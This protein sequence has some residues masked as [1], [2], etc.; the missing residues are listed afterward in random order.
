MVTAAGLL[1]AGL[2]G[3]A[4][5]TAATTI[6]FEESI[7]S[8]GNVTTQYCNDPATNRGVQFFEQ[9]RLIEPASGTS[10]PTHA[11][12]NR[13]SGDEFTESRVM[14]IGF[15]A[16]Q[17]YVSLRVGLDKAYVFPVTAQLRVFTTA[18]PSPSSEIVGQ[19]D[20]LLLGTA[21]TPI[22]RELS[23]TSPGTATP[24]R[25]LEVE[26]TGSAPGNAAVE[27]VDDLTFPTVG[28]PC[29]SDTTPPFVEILEPGPGTAYYGD[30]DGGDVPATLHLRA[31][32]SGTGVATVRVDFV[33]TR[34][35]VVPGFAV[36][37]DVQ[38]EPCPLQTTF[39]DRRFSTYLPDDTVA[40]RV[41]AVDFAGRTGV[42]QRDLTI[43]PSTANVW[44]RG[45][46]ITQ[47]VQPWVATAT[48][49][50]RATA[51]GPPAFNYPYAPDAV[52]LVAGRTTVVRL[53]AAVQGTFAGAPL[54]GV[55]GE[56]RCYLEPS[57]TVHCPGP[58]VVY[59]EQ[60]PPNSTATVTVDPADTL[61]DQRRQAASTLNFVLPRAWVA[62][63]AIHLQATVTS[64]APECA[65]C[66]DAANS[67]RVMSVPF[68]TVPNWHTMVRQVLVDR[69]GKGMATEAE[70]LA[71]LDFIRRL[72]P[73]DEST[74]M[75]GWTLM[76]YLWLSVA[77]AGP[78]CS[79]FLDDLSSAYDYLIEDHG[80]STVWALTDSQTPSWCSGLGRADGVGVSRGDR[81]DSGAH[82][83]GHTVGLK[84]SGPPP[85]F[86]AE[87]QEDYY[88]DDDWPWPLG[89][90]GSFGFD[91]LRLEAH[92]PGPVDAPL[93]HDVMTY[94]DPIWISS[95]TW[96]RLFNAY[97]DSSF[98]YPKA[99]TAAT[100]E[101]SAATTPTPHLLVRA[102]Y[103][104]TAGQWTL[105]PVYEISRTPATPDTG[106][107]DV[108][109]DL[110]DGSGAVLATEGIDLPATEHVDVD[111]PSTIAA[112]DP[113]FVRLV[114]MPPGTVRVVLRDSGGTTLAE[115]ARSASA[116]SVT[117]TAP[118]AAGFT[119]VVRWTWDDADGDPLRALVEYR[120]AADAPWLPLA[121]DAVDDV[122]AVDPTTL[123]GGPAAQVRVTVTD[124][125]ATT[126]ALSAPF[127]KANVAPAPEILQPADGDTLGA[128]RRVVLRG[129]AADVEDEALTGSALVWTSS[130]DGSLGAGT[131]VEV[132][133]L[134]AGTHVITLTATDSA[135]VSRAAAVEVDVQAPLTVNHQ[136]VADAGAD[137][138]V[139]ADSA[140]QLD[141]SGS[142]DADG[143][144]MTYHW[145]VVSA[146]A[147]AGWAFDDPT[148]VAP[149]LFT[150][151][152]GTY[153][154]ELVVHDG[155]VGS[156][157]DRVTRLVDAT[158]PA[159]TIH[160]PAAPPD[161]VV[162]PSEAS[163]DV[164]WS[165]TEAGAY[166]VRVGGTTCTTG[167]VVGSGSYV[168]GTLTSRVGASQLAYGANAVRVCVT[169]S[170]G[171]TGSASVTVYRQVPTAIAYS[172]DTQV[173]APTVPT[174][175]ATLTDTQ[176]ACD[177]A[178]QTVRFSVDLTGDGDV[179]DPGEF[180]G[181]SLTVGSND[182]AV[183]TLQSALGPGIYLVS[184]E[185]AG[186]NE[187]A[188]SF[189]ADGI[190]AVV[191]PDDAASGGGWYQI[192]GATG[193][194]KAVNLGLTTRWSA[195]DQAYRGQILLHDKQAWR[196]KGTITAFAKTSSNPLTGTATGTGALF[197]WQQWAPNVYGYVLVDD[198]VAF[199][200]TFTDTGSSK[201]GGAKPDAFTVNWVTGYSGGA[202]SP[203]VTGSVLQPLKG[204]NLTIR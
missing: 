86:G 189:D 101:P 58:T 143:D 188:A 54:A 97:T 114:A 133:G 51:L 83:I 40:V 145:A 72:H 126:S 12:T 26:L 147:G 135:G 75:N 80:Y 110:L 1:L 47:A 117:V 103:G 190:L 156:R 170:V 48:A 13:F 18:A 144:P 37:G 175:R 142:S 149:T 49:S 107:P 184:V 28:P 108:F 134:S 132:A 100:A 62:T 36:C 46:E 118:T 85:G 95:R 43:A 195:K 98:P 125:L 122:L 191:S 84:H 128:G 32:D 116:P 106:T 92:D 52:P 105:L 73:V 79:E 178:G 76:P 176:A 166:S 199:T 11:A 64:T 30:P 151:L 163:V 179:A 204:G 35:E 50:R 61:T 119:G 78:D 112:A 89:G 187:C 53:F 39:V 167:T 59:P 57:Y 136:P 15:T 65:G 146:P 45:L 60:R 140:V 120:R 139:S 201:K 22:D 6:T 171:N 4:P 16:D 180:R 56:L 148:S 94:G 90:T 186:T 69:A 42:A 130:R 111:P 82:E 77:G 202:V 198:T 137:H 113:S 159:V 104:A 129:N 154:V 74:I 177:V 63:G 2:G 150:T 9:V 5:A 124:G 131:T 31:S 41:T 55:G 88:C 24:I 17:G 19:R 21:A 138:A 192:A 127:A 25:S 14:Q 155:M 102:R 10:T 185:F 164:V 7:P 168:S 121:I 194:S 109:V 162:T 20:T 8:P 153:E 38:G 44:A 160:A 93:E 23:A 71:S 29:V 183:A 67:I 165:A 193:A 68:R 152:P 161:T 3:V 200:V 197:R 158:P 157:P 115:R 181:T 141:G 99:T 174:L 87:C 196:L 27:V 169:D 91:V 81:W 96:T 33:N 66:T 182:S 203:L 123:P 173:V 172:G 34:S 70:R